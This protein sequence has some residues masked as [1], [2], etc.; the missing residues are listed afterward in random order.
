MSRVLIVYDGSQLYFFHSLCLNCFL[1]NI[2]R[3]LI[4]C[5]SICS[6]LS[7]YNLLNCVCTN[8]NQHLEYKRKT[9]P[10]NNNLNPVEQ[11]PNQVT[12]SSFLEGPLLNLTDNLGKYLSRPQLTTISH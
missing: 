5:K 6:F 10:P 8:Y 2:I 4:N 7:D 9:F 12:I 1:K 3:N 11:K